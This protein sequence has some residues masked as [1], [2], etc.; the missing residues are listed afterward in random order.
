METILA[1][2]FDFFTSPIPFVQGDLPFTPLQ[3][4]LFFVIPTTAVIV[5]YR[6][7][8]LG[9]R[10]I[11]ERV[12][13]DD[14]G[15]KKV[16]R[17]SR[18]VLRTLSIAVISLFALRMFGSEMVHYLQ[19]FYGILS[20]PFFESGN[21]RI[22]II[23]LLLTMPI[24][25]FASW[26]SRVVKSF[27][28]SNILSSLSIDDAQRFSVSNLIR[29]GSMALVVIIGLSIVGINL[30]SLAV[31]FG[32]L[33]I[34][35]GFGLQ[36][37][38]GNFFAGMTIFVT[39]PIKEGDRILVGEN[40]GTVT[41][42]RLIS[43]VVNTITNE[44]LIIPNRVLINSSVHNF[45]FKDKKIIIKNPVEVSYSADI[46]R[47]LE[48]LREVGRKNPYG[49]MV[50]E[51]EARLMSFNSSGIGLVLFTWI[52]DA[53]QKLNAVSWG[54]LEIWRAFKKE[55]VEIPFPQVDVHIKETGASI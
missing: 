35:L 18:F 39:R 11:L 53:T 41:H 24:F 14:D 33:G 48:V 30:S 55:G 32:V 31:I 42:I 23:T 25:Y 21:T 34:G 51:P 12:K 17:W 9:I 1:V 27:I 37:L 45:S 13:L 10:K 4:L 44:S 7:A 49:L 47:A 20:E 3:L 38:V 15:K 16:L 19:L 26:V 28:D 54:N 46:D 5:A 29:Y 22:S 2:I 52:G 40:E 50:P 6:L 8:I 36:E 43:T